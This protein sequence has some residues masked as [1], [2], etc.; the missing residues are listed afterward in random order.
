VRREKSID[1][2][3]LEFAL[4]RVEVDPLKEHVSF[5]IRDD[6]LSYSKSA[7]LARIDKLVAGH[8]LF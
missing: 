7:L 2:L 8:S 3:I 5:W 1:S 4:E 6:D